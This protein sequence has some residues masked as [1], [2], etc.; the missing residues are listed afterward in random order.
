M[1]YHLHPLLI[2]RVNIT[3]CNQLCLVLEGN[4]I[5]FCVLQVRFGFFL[6]YP[7]LTL[8]TRVLNSYAVALAASFGEARIL[9][10]Y[11]FSG[12]KSSLLIKSILN[13]CDFLKYY[14]HC[15]FKVESITCSH[16]SS[17]FPCIPAKDVYVSAVMRFLGWFIS[18]LAA[19]F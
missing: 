2:F 11:F 12:N 15:I 19:R 17:V 4:W 5:L 14:L 6:I 7:E 18:Q 1:T 8:P 9:I 16:R 13:L 3:L 10:F